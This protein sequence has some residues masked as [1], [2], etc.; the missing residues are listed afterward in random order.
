LSDEEVEVWVAV[1]NAEPA[2]HF[3]ASTTPLLAQYCRHVIS[4]RRVAELIETCKLNGVDPQATCV[5]SLR[6]AAAALK[7]K[8]SAS[9]VRKAAYR[10]AP[11]RQSRS[12]HGRD[13]RVDGIPWSL[14]NLRDG[15]Q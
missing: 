12:Q 13:H 4:S 11:G 14:S 9:W 5:T 1:T 15:P 3:S 7:V 2:D 8:R 6:R 10:S